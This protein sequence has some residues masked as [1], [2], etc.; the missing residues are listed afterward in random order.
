MN[1]SCVFTIFLWHWSLNSTLGSNHFWSFFLTKSVS[2]HDSRQGSLAKPLYCF[3]Y[4]LGRRYHLTS[5]LWFC[6]SPWIFI[7]LKNFFKLPAPG[8]E[9]LTLGLQV[10]HSPLHHGDSPLWCTISNLLKTWVFQSC[11]S[12]NV[13]FTFNENLS[14]SCREHWSCNILNLLLLTWAR[15]FCGYPVI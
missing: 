9:P 1:E 3:S 8:I 7:Q 11:H 6:G 15:N 4:I 13:S 12:M 10:Q 14:S 5:L 2:W